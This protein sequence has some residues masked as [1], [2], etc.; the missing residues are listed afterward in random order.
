[1]IRRAVVRSLASGLRRAL[2]PEAR[3]FERALGAPA[4]AQ[5][6]VLRRLVA[7]LAGTQYGRA[8]GLGA[9]DGHAAF[10]ARLP[11]VTYDDL[12]P[13]VERQMRETAPVLVPGPVRVWEKTSGSAGPAKYV[14]Y[15]AA[16][17]RSFGRLFRL[18]LADLLSH[19]PSLESGRTWI[20]V[21]PRLG[22]PETVAAGAPVGLDSELDH[23]DGA[24]RALLAPFM[25]VPP[26]VG[27]MRDPESVK[28]VLACA[29]VAGRC[30]VLSVWS[31]AFLLALLDWIGRHRAL[32]AA[33]LRAGAVSVE[34]GS[35]RLPPPVPGVLRA[36]GSEPIPWRRVLSELKLVSCWADGPAAALAAELARALP[37]VP[38][39]GKG[40]LA[41]EAPLTVPWT[42]AGGCV[43]LLHEV[44]LE[45]ADESGA[46]CRLHELSAG[47][48]YSLIVT[49]AGGL[50]RYR[51]GDR[52]RVSAFHRGTPVLAFVGRE[53][54]VSDMVGEKLDE[55]FVRAELDALPLIPG[56]FR[57]LL[58]S[59]RPGAPARYVLLV[60][61]AAVAAGAPVVDLAGRLDGR[62]QRAHR[63]RE[64]RLLGQLDP[65]QIVVLPS[66]Q[67]RLLDAI[68]AAGTPRGA[69]KPAS[70]VRDPALAERLLAGS[71]R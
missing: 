46:T 17:R 37:E 29:L 18:W 8:H 4:A 19:G 24:L 39:Q 5:D 47:A 62:L 60:D 22:P 23:V 56:G 32:V 21:S 49:Q 14:P 9:A 12:R 65:P 67:D 2:A 44:F 59:R 64:A 66:A 6:A 70:M 54:L 28:R 33:D 55:R 16:L 69:V 30:E 3:A 42:A 45:F 48:E 34:G 40:L 1:V 26:W 61:R 20:S 71:R 35:L 52:V 36:L 11:V 27:R 31:P 63:Y 68:E 13:W 7:G 10:A 41:T 43:P 51:I 38:I 15:P 57:M 50:A 58:P 53:G 25:V